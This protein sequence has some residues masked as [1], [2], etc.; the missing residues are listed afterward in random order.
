MRK[1]LFCSF[2]APLLAAAFLV[3]CGPE[4]YPDDQQ[5]PYPYPDG[6]YEG[7]NGEHGDVHGTVESVNPR[8]RLIYLD[9]RNGE[10]DRPPIVLSY[11]DGT[12]VRYQGQ[13][14]RPENLERG[15]RIRV[16]IDRD[17]EG[18]LFAESIDVLYD[19]S[20]GGPPPGEQ[21]PPGEPGAAPRDR[22]ESR[23]DRLQGIIRSIDTDAQTLE[24]VDRGGASVTVGFDSHTPVHFEGNLYGPD[25]L[26]EGDEVRIRVHDYDGRLFAQDIFVVRDRRRRG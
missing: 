22:G 7:R 3:G 17:E 16:H 15:D 2:L 8:E 18:R 11:D 5:H 10:R 21:P 14:Y 25:N 13:T 24:I 23:A 20:Q 12:V 6:Q 4:Y 1:I 19:V 26:E 9:E